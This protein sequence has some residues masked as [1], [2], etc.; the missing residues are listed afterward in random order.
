MSAGIALAMECISNDTKFLSTSRDFKLETDLDCKHE[1]LKEYG[2]IIPDILLGL[3]VWI[4]KT[5]LYLLE[6]WDIG[7][8]D[9]H[10]TE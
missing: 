7:N 5:P 10:K 2:A 6:A 3:C 9:G 4:V 8:D 1:K